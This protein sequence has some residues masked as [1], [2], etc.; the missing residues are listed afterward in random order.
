MKLCTPAMIYFV[1]SFLSLAFSA[2][3]NFNIAT[4]LFQSIFIILWSQLLNYFCE[5]GYSVL[6]WILVFF[7]FVLALFILMGLIRNLSHK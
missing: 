2:I 7:P 5:K 6:S 4:I 1:L 3:Y